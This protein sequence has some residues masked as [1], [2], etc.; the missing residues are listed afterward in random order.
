MKVRLGMSR[1]PD[2]TR[3]Q[4]QWQMFYTWLK[5]QPGVNVEIID[6]VR[7]IPELVFT[8]HLGLVFRRCF[9]RSRSREY[10]R[11]HEEIEIERWFRKK[12][13]DVR[14]VPEPFFFDG[15]ADAKV[16]GDEIVTGYASRA[17]LE[18]LERVEGMLKRQCSA[19]ELK[20]EK[21]GKLADCFGPLNAGVALVFS[22]AFET[23]SLSV[24][25]ELVDN[26][27]WVMEDEAASGVCHSFSAGQQVVLPPKCPRIKETLE[28]KGFC[29]TE[30][31]L[32][33]FAKAGISASGLVLNI[34]I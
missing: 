25:K 11:R 31:D 5:N 28:Q 20:A 10:K 2:L 12:N 17:G 13:Y 29:V 19:L 21:C 16:M 6:P 14:T 30:M 15:G 18:S 24:V 8:N 7:E 27:V 9:I 26:P 4:E 23:Y 33:E 34:G 22:E 3:L 1:A 32:S